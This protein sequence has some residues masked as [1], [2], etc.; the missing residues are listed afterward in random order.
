MKKI[1]LLFLVLFFIFVAADTAVADKDPG[2]TMAISVKEVS[3]FVY[4]CIPHTGPFTEIEKIIGQL[5]PAMQSQ[6]VAPAGPMIGI[7]YNSP[8]EVKPEELQWEIGFPVTAQVQVLAPLEKKIWEYKTVVSA[9]HIGPYE[10][11]GE[12]IAKM[13][14]WMNAEGLAMIGPLMERYLTMPTPGTKPEDMKTEIW[15]PCKKN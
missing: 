6:N 12:T 11:T 5:M 15:I 10:N 4:C 13:M 8:E 9:I 2:E 7:F 3:P 1:L 14:E